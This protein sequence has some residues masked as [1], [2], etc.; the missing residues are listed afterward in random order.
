MPLV[1][2]PDKRELP[3]RVW[4]PY[5]IHDQWNY[6][7]TYAIELGPMIVGILLNVTTDVVIS[8]F[9]LQACIQL[10]MLKHRLNKLPDIVKEAKRRK[11][12]SPETVRL[13]ER[14]TLHQAAQHHDYIIKYNF[15][16]CRVY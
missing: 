4:L 15:L 9:V 5:D 13:F 3:F 2:D 7:L 12:A 16:K 8:G 11:L 10:D 6:W 1:Q 14:K